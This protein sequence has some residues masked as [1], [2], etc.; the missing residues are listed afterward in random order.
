MYDIEPVSMYGSDGCMGMDASETDTDHLYGT[1]MRLFSFEEIHIYNGAASPA[2]TPTTPSRGC[3]L[4]SAS[5][6][7]Q[8]AASQHDD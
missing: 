7:V 2:V 1:Q 5:S 6:L 8:A 4:G 3:S